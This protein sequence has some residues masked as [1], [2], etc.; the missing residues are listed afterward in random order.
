MVD[1]WSIEITDHASSISTLTTHVFSFYCLFTFFNSCHLS[2]DM[3]EKRAYN[4]RS[5]GSEAVTV[6]LQFEVSDENFM[7]RL[8]QCQ[9][10]TSQSGQ[11]LDSGSENNSNMSNAESDNE[12]IQGSESTG[13]DK[14]VPSSLNAFRNQ[15]IDTVSQQAINLQILSQLGDISRRLHVIENKKPKKSSDTSK[16]KVP[17]LSGSI[18]QSHCLPPRCLLNL[19]QICNISEMMYIFRHK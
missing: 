17:K 7:S 12:D 10:S 18:P 15:N 16:I 14:Q 2:F 3:S 13:V 8:L 4:L 5:G 9:E 1:Q 11:V 6:P 19:F